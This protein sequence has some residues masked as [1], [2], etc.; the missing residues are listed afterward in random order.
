MPTWSA[1]IGNKSTEWSLRWYQVLVW[2]DGP[3]RLRLRV[4]VELVDVLIPWTWLGTAA[5]RQWVTWAQQTTTAP[6]CCRL[7]YIE[8]GRCRLE[9]PVNLGYHPI[10]GTR[11]LVHL[12]CCDEI[13]AV[14]YLAMQHVWCIAP[15]SSDTQWLGG[16]VVRALDLRETD[17][18]ATHLYFWKLLF[19]PD[20]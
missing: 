9:T 5:E 14:Q 19:S 7:C 15:C 8:P 20:P 2:V 6:P 12:Q 18:L 10:L 11:V 17:R 16:V 1:K 13:F 4:L 3:T